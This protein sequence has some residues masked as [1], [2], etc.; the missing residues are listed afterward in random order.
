MTTQPKTARLSALATHV[1]GALKGEDCPITG[2]A[3]VREAVSGQVTFLANP[4]YAHDLSR[5]RAS[6][7]VIAPEHPSAGLARIE[8]A[9]PYY[10]F[11]R[12][13]RW[14]HQQPYRSRAPVTTP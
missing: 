13:V 1:G 10:A 8:V 2:V 6:A 14:F 4:R 9:D 5:T 3:G 11:S 12:I 7:V